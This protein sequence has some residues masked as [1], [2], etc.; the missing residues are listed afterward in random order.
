MRHCVRLLVQD[1]DLRVSHW[2]NRE[3]F[4]GALRGVQC[5]RLGNCDD[6]PTRF[7]AL[8]IHS[9]GNDVPA[10]VIGVCYCWQGL[11]PKIAIWNQ[12]LL[13]GFEDRLVMVSSPWSAEGMRQISLPGLF[14]DMQILQV[15][16]T[17]VVTSEYGVTAVGMDGA[18][19]GEDA[20]DLV[21][22]WSLED[23]LIAIRYS[24]GSIRTLALGG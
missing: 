2:E 6:S 5:I 11:T 20:H 9:A 16:E 21:E 13:L 7:M 17:V 1:L 3:E 24:D 22:G 4:E 14:H 10:C 8:Y 15:R 19:I 12:M 18:V 23:N